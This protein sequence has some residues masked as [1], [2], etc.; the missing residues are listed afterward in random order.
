MV[1]MAAMQ[2]DLDDTI[3]VMIG[4]RNLSILN[5]MLLKFRIYWVR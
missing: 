4:A 1:L 5:I 3:F 2:N